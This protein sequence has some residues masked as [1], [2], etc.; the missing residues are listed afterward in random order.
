M[1]T[2]SVAVPFSRSCEKLDKLIGH[3]E[4]QLG[5]KEP[6]DV[7]KAVSAQGKPAPA[8]DVPSNPSSASIAS[9]GRAAVGGGASSAQDVAAKPKKEKVDKAAAP[10]K[11]PPV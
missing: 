3:L 2:S 4:S 7:K 10:P 5:V 6:F 11:M 8:V 9:D 1:S